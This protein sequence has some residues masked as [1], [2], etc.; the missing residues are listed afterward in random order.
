MHLIS[1]E[2]LFATQGDADLLSPDRAGV[3]VAFAK[4]LIHIVCILTGLMRS[5]N[6][7]FHQ[8][9]YITIILFWAHKFMLPKYLARMLLHIA[10][11]VQS[12]A[13]SQGLC[14]E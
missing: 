14:G 3:V 9:L 4:M 13:F 2:Q 5:V 10:M 12:H 7:C 6:Q 1:I 11:V 8:H